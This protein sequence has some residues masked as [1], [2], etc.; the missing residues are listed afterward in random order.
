M[1]DDT[2]VVQIAAAKRAAPITI[3]G[4]SLDGQR[5][6]SKS[7]D[8]IVVVNAWASWCRTCILEWRDLQEVARDNPDVEFLGLN[9]SDSK[10]AALKFLTTHPTNYEHIFDPDNAILNKIKDLPS[11]SIPT[12]L[13]LDKQHRIAARILGQVYRGKLQE[14][15][16]NLRAE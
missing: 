3:S 2:R 8:G 5:I 12:T 11:L 13:I 9:E 6:S 14:I 10:Q 4:I 15:L 7:L 1:Q 16:S